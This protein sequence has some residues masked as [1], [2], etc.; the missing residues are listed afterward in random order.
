ML[1]LELKCLLRLISE[2]LFYYCV[3]IMD[4]F[5]MCCKV[6]GHNSLLRTSMCHFGRRCAPQK[7]KEN[8]AG[9]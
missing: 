8:L 3:F 1:H 7:F 6:I 5:P 9:G 2:T 4:C